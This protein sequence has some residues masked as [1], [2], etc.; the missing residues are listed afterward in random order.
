M[1][2]IGGIYWFDG[3][4]EAIG[5]TRQLIAD[6]SRRGPDGQS[7]CNTGPTVFGHGKLS[8]TLESLT[9]VQP[10]SSEDQRLLL[11][12]DGRLD[13]RD[14][15]LR[16]L[17][18]FS[19][20]RNAPD[21]ELVLA[22]YRNWGDQCIKHL[23]GDFAFAIWDQPDQRLFCARDRVGA[24]PFYFVRTSRFF[25]FASEAEVLAKLP[26]VDVEANPDWI[27]SM[28]VPDFERCIDHR[29]SWL[30][31]IQSLGAGE[32]L[33]VTAG[34]EPKI[35]CYWHLEP[36]EPGFRFNEHEVVEQFDELLQRSVSRRLRS[37]T[38]PALMLSGGLD[39]TGIVA[40]LVRDT[41]VAD[42]SIH[43]FSLVGA[44][45]SVD[46]EMP[47]IRELA[48]SRVLDPRFCEL[49]DLTGCGGL[50]ALASLAW[51]SDHA[52][53]IDNSVLLPMLMFRKA[54]AQGKRVM[55]H[56]AS[57][58]L[59]NYT[60]THYGSYLIKAGK[61]GQAWAESKAASQNNPYL[62]NQ[63]AVKIFLNDLARSARIRLPVRNWRARRAYPG[64][65]ILQPELK[66]RVQFHSR[67][68]AYYAACRNNALDDVP[69]VHVNVLQ[70]LSMR[71]G[72]EAY[73]RVASRFGIEA[74]DPWADPEL[75]QFMVSL[76]MH[77]RT[78]HGWSKYLLRASLKDEFTERVVWRKDKQHL[79]TQ[80][81]GRL[82]NATQ[83]MSGDGGASDSSLY[84]YLAPSGVASNTNDWH[85]QRNLK[86]RDTIIWVKTLELWLARL[87]EGDRQ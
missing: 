73:D 53:P 11:T 63:S 62:I 52:H 74:R 13:N 6:M 5:F 56:G 16:V 7:V 84:G 22:A 59:V 33:S 54:A 77:W 28:F 36:I 38:E 18:S 41:S 37:D 2:A 34:A 70:S 14:E 45:N 82:V 81:L 65:E 27:I 30:D 42:Q 44:G 20:G 61:W 80:L 1:S 49:P 32:T 23:H 79:G 55:L 67:M 19:P 8:A 35:A 17:S 47:A 50:E 29:S 25:A 4:P 87:G 3:N 60:P 48:R 85:N 86:A 39:T 12:W 51:D 31:P 75:L 72:L 46:L 15:L 57:G 9:E 68:E 21:S 58:D 69:R 26:G 43:G 71:I 24:R 10:L 83:G 78:R 76:P 66:D 64:E 40:A